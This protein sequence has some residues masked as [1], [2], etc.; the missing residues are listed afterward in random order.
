MEVA[1]AHGAA[2]IKAA[3]IAGIDTIE[4]V[5]THEIGHTLGLRHSDYYNRTISCGSGGNEGSAGV[6][7]ILALLLTGGELNVIATT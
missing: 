4:H 2:G 5:I 7:A 1:H 6:G 3:L